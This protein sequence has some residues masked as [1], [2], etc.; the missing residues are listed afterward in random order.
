M[1][2]SISIPCSSFGRKPCGEIEIHHALIASYEGTGETEK[3][4]EAVNE[5]MKYAGTSE[6]LFL[7]LASLTLRRADWGA[8]LDAAGRVLKN[9]PENAEAKEIYE[10]C[11]PKVFGK[12]EAAAFSA[13]ASTDKEQ[14]AAKDNKKKGKGKPKAIQVSF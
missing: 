6:F 5:A 8:A 7:K 11:A 14:P 3:A 1:N 2:Q 4:E 12:K 13:G 9:N 10:R